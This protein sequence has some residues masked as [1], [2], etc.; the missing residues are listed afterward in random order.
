MSVATRSAV[1]V[2]RM[3]WVAIALVVLT[4]FLLIRS[5]STALMNGYPR[6]DSYRVL[7]ERSIVVAVAVAPRSWTRLTAL[8]QTES[9]VR[10]IVESLDWPIPLPGT[11]DLEL[12]ELT[13]ALAADL[14]TRTVRDANGQ[15]IPP[16]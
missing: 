4:I 15:P 1:R 10:V 11:A 6:M 14:G 3:V 2:S 8:E 5:N 13:I 7:N 16:R 12:R 9:E